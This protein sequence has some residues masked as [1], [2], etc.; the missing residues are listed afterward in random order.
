M[1][2][3]KNSNVPVTKDVFKTIMVLKTS[4]VTGAL[5]LAHPVLGSY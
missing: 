3:G 2:G 4:L 5:L 1:A